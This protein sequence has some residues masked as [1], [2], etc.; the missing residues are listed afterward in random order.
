MARPT[1][2]TTVQR[3][4]L[5][6]IAYEY[7]LE[8]SQ[9]GFIGAEVMPFF[10]VAEQSGDYPRIPMEALL[11]EP[12]T[13][14]RARSGYARSDWEFETGNYATKERGFEEPI[15]DSEASLYARYFDAEEVATM[16][17]MDVVLRGHERRVAADLFNTSNAVGNSAVSVEWSTAA[18]CTPRADVMAGKQAMRAASGLEPNAMVISKKVF[19]NLLV[20][21]EIGNRFQYTA[22]LETRPMSAQ[23]DALAQY[24]DVGRL[25][26]GGA[27]RNSAKKGQAFSLSDIWDDEYC[28]LCVLSDG[29]NDLRMPAFGR[30]FLWTAD[31]PDPVVVETYREEQTRSDVVRARHH[32]DEATV[33]TGANYL[34]TNITA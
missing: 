22:P 12:N 18:T 13:D 19:E 24:F 14:R 25:L 23:L 31:S 29:G 21:A 6:T 28:S 27:L 9:R 3:P 10:P 34:L 16:R 26:V 1:S 8:A 20:C 4:E 17:C 7:M 32:V 5:G 2:S 15:D 30:T 33:F 11:T